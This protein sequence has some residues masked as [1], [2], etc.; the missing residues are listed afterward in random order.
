MEEE[1]RPGHYEFAI[2]GAFYHVTARSNERKAA[3]KSIR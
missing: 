1:I 2:P 3:F